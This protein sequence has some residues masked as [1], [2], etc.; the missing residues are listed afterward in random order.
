[1]EVHSGQT[2]WFRWLRRQRIRVCGW[3]QAG[4]TAKGQWGELRVSGPG[5]AEKMRRTKVWGNEN[6]N[7]GV[8][9]ALFWAGAVSKGSERGWMTAAQFWGGRK[10]S[11]WG[12]WGPV[13]GQK[14]HSR[15]RQGEGY[16]WKK[17]KGQWAT[18][19]PCPQ[20]SIS[21]C[22]DFA[23]SSD[24][25]VPFQ[26]PRVSVRPCQALRKPAWNSN[27]WLPDASH[28]VAWLV[29]WPT[30]ASRHVLFCALHHIRS[31]SLVTVLHLF[32]AHTRVFKWQIKIRP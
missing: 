31:F 18:S 7:V 9:A 2:T 6:W 1:M 26:H 11:S 19:Y 28:S 17:A 25:G 4:A 22:Q 5:P 13:S 15:V 3:G 20:G 14:S 23:L 27:S 16:T 32:S 29:E 21:F 8:P 10:T 30:S 24:M 12:C